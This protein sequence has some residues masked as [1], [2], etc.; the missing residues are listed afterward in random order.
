LRLLNGIQARLTELHDGSDVELRQQIAVL[1]DERDRELLEVEAARGFALERIER[2]YQEEKR[3]ADKEYQVWIPIPIPS[4]S[5]LSSLEALAFVST[6]LCP[7]CMFA[8]LTP[9]RSAEKKEK[10]NS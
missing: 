3:L 7:W 9:C 1:E 6:F 8:I 2:E 5:L 10:T 4:Y